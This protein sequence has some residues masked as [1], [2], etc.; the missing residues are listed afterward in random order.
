MTLPR[1][2][3][4]TFN[5]PFS[6]ASS[7]TASRVTVKLPEPIEYLKRPSVPG[8]S[9]AAHDAAA[10]RNDANEIKTALLKQIK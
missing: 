2:R 8:A 5:M 6:G 4:D 1:A 3:G 10:N 9:E 7:F